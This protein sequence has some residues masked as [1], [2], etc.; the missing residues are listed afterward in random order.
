M[1]WQETP[2]GDVRIS[3]TLQRKISAH[4]II[5]CA[6]ILT[7]IL[8][9]V[10]LIA[11][12]WPLTNS[13]EGTIGIMALHIAYYGAHPT[14]FYGQNY[15]G[16]WEALLGAGIF[17]LFGPSLF[18]LRMGTVCMFAL[19][20]VSFYLLS[21][22]LFSRM[23]TLVALLLA[24]TGSGFMITQEVRAIG[25][26]AETL[27]FC[28][29][30]FLCATWLALTYQFKPTRRARIARYLV[31]LL[32]GL[33][34]GVGLWTDLLILPP[35]LASGV[36]LLVVCWRE[37]LRPVPLFCLLVGLCIGAFPLIYY[38]LHAAPGQDSLSILRGLRGDSSQIY[39]PGALLNEIG[40]TFQI[41]VPLITGEPFCPVTEIPFL[42]PNSPHT[43]ACTAA[44]SIWSAGYLLLFALACA[45]V[46]RGAWSLWRRRKHPD[47]EP[48]LQYALR[49]QIA[50]LI[51]LL[52]TALS[53]ALYTFSNAPLSGPGLHA[54][55]LI[56]LLTATPAVFWPLWQGLRVTKT[57]SGFAPRA[58]QLLSAAGLCLFCGMSVLGSVLAFTEVPAAAA[59]NQSDATLINTLEHLNIRHIYTDYWTCDKIAFE[60]D[61]RII[62]AVLNAEMKRD[63]HNR[64]APY[65]TAVSAD[66]HAAYVFPIDQEKYAPAPAYA[67]LNNPNLPLS[68]LPTLFRTDYIRVVADSYV[69]YVHR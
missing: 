63:S 43:L 68:A 55:Y 24:G 33:T 16:S 25:G 54:R 31:Y 32:W 9:H 60:S 2:A 38:N 8:L 49:Q 59:L 23:W 11:L 51:L 5:A 19:F 13:D 37:L 14:F 29:L 45:L 22:L 58:I 50:R 65:Y 61:E 47:N 41:S 62:C 20:L 34:A 3:L 18:T 69:M 7:A 46:G 64:Y 36:L 53:L 44:R 15:M 35:L 6:L 40:N 26:Y 12:G 67:F 21:R 4:G 28:T 56:C 66:P 17:R 1:L 52:G 10:V 27:F 30:L 39:T 57:R 48:K 42:G